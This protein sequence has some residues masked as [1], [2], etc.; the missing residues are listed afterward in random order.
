MFD[1][2]KWL[3]AFAKYTTPK[4][5]TEP[6]STYVKKLILTSFSSFGIECKK[7]IVKKLWKCICKASRRASFPYPPN[8]HTHTHTHT[9]T[10]AHTHTF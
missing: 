8:T 7:L 9:H 1:E 5:T 6:Q 10:Q 4:F 2:I 3:C